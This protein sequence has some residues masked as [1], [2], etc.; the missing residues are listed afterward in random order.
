[1][2]ADEDLPR[3]GHMIVDAMEQQA[4][5]AGARPVHKHIEIFDD[6]VSPPGYVYTRF[7][8]RDEEQAIKLI[9]FGGF[10]RSVW[11]GF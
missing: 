8:H 3:I 4:I 9:G 5:V 1:M 10:F 11:Q 2:I 6:S 7:D